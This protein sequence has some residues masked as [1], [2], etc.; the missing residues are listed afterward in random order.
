MFGK[1]VW[2]LQR[3]NNTKKR[4][5]QEFLIAYIVVRIKLNMG[6]GKEKQKCGRN[7][8]FNKQQMLVIKNLKKKKK[9]V[10]ALEAQEPKYV[11]CVC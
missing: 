2:F 1:L 6:G 10:R 8:D 11:Q 5:L 3:N 4:T 9:C 7:I